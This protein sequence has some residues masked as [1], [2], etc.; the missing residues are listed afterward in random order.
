MDN[1]IKTQLIAEVAR[2]IGLPIIP[3]SPTAVHDSKPFPHLVRHGN[4]RLFL[5]GQLF[6]PLANPQHFLLVEA[7]LERSG[8]AYQY[9]FEPRYN[10]HTFNIQFG[11]SFVFD[12]RPLAGCMALVHQFGDAELEKRY[13]E[14][15]LL[16]KVAG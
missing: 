14:A 13:F 16:E 9:I 6:D 2:I 1:D 3:M 10:S 7:W 11:M 4:G 5:D 12:K 15:L 8:L